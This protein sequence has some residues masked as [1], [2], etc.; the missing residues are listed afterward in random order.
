[1][2]SDDRG[3]RERGKIEGAGCVATLMKNEGN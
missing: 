1:M 3:E 2:T